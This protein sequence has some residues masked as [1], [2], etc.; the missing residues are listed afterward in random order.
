MMLGFLQDLQFHIYRI[1]TMI[2]S[3][4]Y[5]AR[6]IT[7]KFKTMKLIQIFNLMKVIKS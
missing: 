1:T 2:L 3:T 4:V 5:F 6:V 7:N